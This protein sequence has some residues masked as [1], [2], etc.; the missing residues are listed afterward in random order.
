MVRPGRI[1][2]ELPRS[3]RLQRDSEF[4]LVRASGKSWTGTHLILAALHREND[5]PSR[6]GIITTRRLGNA[7]VRNR[8]RR[9]IREI[10]RLNQH[11]VRQG[12]WVVTIA[13][14]SSALASYRELERDW[15]RLAKRASI[16]GRTP[17]GSNPA[18]L[19]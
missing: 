13:R 5:S 11:H 7:V 14:I 18:D 2:F 12:Y 17:H 9:K 19:T 8:I 6:V 4:K 16:L 10:F 15:L 3:S 1:G